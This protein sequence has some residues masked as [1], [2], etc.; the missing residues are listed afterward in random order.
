MHPHGQTL[1]NWLD[2]HGKLAGYNDGNH[3][4]D[5]MLYRVPSNSLNSMLARFRLFCMGEALDEH[6][7]LVR[8]SESL[9]M[10][11]WLPPLSLDA[12]RALLAMGKGHSMLQEATERCAF[13][14]LC[15]QLAHHEGQWVDDL[16]PIAE[17]ITPVVDRLTPQAMAK[18]GDLRVGF[19]VCMAALMVQRTVSGRPKPPGS[20]T[21]SVKR[22][23]SRFDT[24]P[25]WCGAAL[26]WWPQDRR[27]KLLLGT[28]HILWGVI[29][30]CPTLAVLN[31]ALDHVADQPKAHT[32]GL[33]EHL[34]E[35]GTWVKPLLEE[36]LCAGAGP[37]RHIFLGALAR[38]ADAASI[39]ALVAMLGDGREAN[40]TQASE[41]LAAL[42]PEVAQEAVLEALTA[43]RKVVRHSAAHTV[44]Q[45]RCPTMTCTALE[46]ATDPQVRTLLMEALDDSPVEITPLEQL[47]R[48]P[49]ELGYSQEEVHRWDKR[50]QE[51]T[52]PSVGYRVHPKLTKL[53][54]EDTARVVVLAT[55]LAKASWLTEALVCRW[56]SVVLAHKEHPLA[57]WAALWMAAVLPSNEQI[58]R[59]AWMARFVETWGHERLR[60]PTRVLSLDK[61]HG[62]RVWLYTWACDHIDHLGTLHEEMLADSSEGGRQQAAKM[63]AHQGELEAGLALAKTRFAAQRAD[64]RHGAA[65]LLKALASPEALPLIEEQLTQERSKRVKAA[66]KEARAWCD[67]LLRSGVVARPFGAY[68]LGQPPS[69][70]QGLEELRVLM[71]TDAP[72][73]V[74]W[75]RLCNLL[76]RFKTHGGLELA[77][78]YVQTH[79]LDPW[80]QPLRVLPWSW[81]EHEALASLVGVE[82]VH[83]D[84]APIELMAHEERAW[85]FIRE[86]LEPLERHARTRLFERK[87]VPLFTAWVQK[88]WSWCEE[89]GVPFGQ[90]QVR[91]DGGSVGKKYIQLGVSSSLE[92]WN[93]YGV[94]VSR[95]S[96]CRDEGRGRHHGLRLLRIVV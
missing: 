53:A 68:V 76:D 96:V 89:H 87:D 36:R 44:A 2:Q 7:E 11:Y 47:Q 28:P 45:W 62:Q 51:Y 95:Q 79:G 48:S 81:Q 85:H 1:L 61:R 94:H 39:P 3:L 37:N 91:V 55:R 92:L 73:P 32:H 93:G 50:L 16:R 19:I 29:P 60:Q 5:L 56:W 33:E 21:S 90:L 38:M 63:L 13:V 25:T 4:R 54:Q 66:L 31:Q 57:L 83:K 8:L 35:L 77:L 27:E 34:V 40:R 75:M 9:R 42:G 58:E 59:E 70:N 72:S 30:C 86:T 69:L 10:P 41:T 74:G 82:E 43:G 64:V 46:M 49:E 80:P 22:I 20:F 84:V 78:D 15:E 17:E 65:L 88:G 23:L 14:A 18:Q 67:P 12:V 24:I 6:W 26:E 52:H 71:H